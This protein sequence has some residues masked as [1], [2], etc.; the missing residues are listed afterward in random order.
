MVAEGTLGP[1]Q[2]H[3]SQGNTAVSSLT[4]EHAP[5]VTL[6]PSVDALPACY[7]RAHPGV[8]VCLEREYSCIALAGPG[9]IR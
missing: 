4:P 6:N 3:A 1:S 5:A 7:G 2:G 9:L 8:F